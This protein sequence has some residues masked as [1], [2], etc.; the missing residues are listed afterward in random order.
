MRGEYGTPKLLPG[1]HKQSALRRELKN[2]LYFIRRQGR[3]ISHSGIKG[4]AAQL[5][6]WMAHHPWG[7]KPSHPVGG[8]VKHRIEFHGPYILL[9]ME[10]KVK[11]P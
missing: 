7:Q 6:P 5:S 4:A 10:A 11:R 2:L 1:V 3:K 9:F 8:G